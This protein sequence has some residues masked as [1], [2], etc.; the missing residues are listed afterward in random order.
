MVW[1]S[2]TWDATARQYRDSRGRFVPRRQVRQALDEAI[3]RAKAEI[4]R[5]ARALQAG[6]INLPEWQIRTENQLRAIH[7]MS[8]AV[9]AGGWAQATA[10]DWAR[11]GNRLKKQYRYLE[12]F[13]RQIEGGEQPLDGRF[14]VRAESYATAGSGTYEAVLRRID[15]GRAVVLAERRVL[16]STS[17]CVPCLGY[18]A[19]GWQPPETLPDIGEE[20]ECG[21]RCQCTFQRRTLP[22][23]AIR[24]RPSDRAERDDYETV[25]VDVGK[26]NEG[27]QRDRGFAIGKGGAGAVGGRLAGF[28]D[29]LRKHVPGGTRV[30]QPEVTVDADGTVS[31]VD[32]RHRFAVLRDMGVGRMPVS[33]PRGQAGRVRRLFG[34]K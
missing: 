19:L 7:T 14:L 5:D 13:A 33:V 28:K 18:H 10:A 17:P 8:A 24:F 29:W 25:L 9:A 26:L 22:L 32:G 31:F 2:F 34:A 12:R 16:H 6:A 1:P 27:F 15:L 4:A 11:A 30:E 20:C 23:S 3:D 21:M